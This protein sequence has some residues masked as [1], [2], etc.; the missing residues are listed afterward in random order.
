MANAEVV[1]VMELR[2]GKILA[3]V[4]REKQLSVKAVSRLSGVPASTIRE[5]LNNRAPKNPSDVKRVAESLGVSLHFLLFGEEDAFQS[6]SLDRFL[7][8][9][10][11]ND[12]FQ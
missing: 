11:L 12:S 5:R 8:D 4:I 7:K 9:E 2:I 10:V 3:N 1:K 6:S